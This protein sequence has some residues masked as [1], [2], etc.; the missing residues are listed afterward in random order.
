M[1]LKPIRRH[2]GFM[3]T[4]IRSKSSPA[5]LTSNIP[6]P[7]EQDGDL[8]TVPSCDD[9]IDLRQLKD[10]N[11]LAKTVL[12]VAR[13][14]LPEWDSVEEV[15][16]KR[17]SG[18]M[19]NAVYFMS[20]PDQPRVLLRVYGVGADQ[21]VDR[22]HE[23][24]WLARLSRM[25]TNLSPALLATF[26]NGRFEEYLESTTLTYNDMRTPDISCQIALSLRQLHDITE[27]YPPPENCRIECWRNISTWYAYVREM[28]NQ[29]EWKQKLAPLGLETLPK[30]IEELKAMT[31]KSKSPIVFAH[32]D[33]QYG[34]VLRMEKTGE[35]VVVDFE[36]AGYNPRGYDIANH[37]CEW[38]YDYHGDNSASMHMEWFP[39]NEEQLRF[40]NAY[41]EGGD[42]MG[43]TAEEL[44]K[45][46]LD[47]VIVT[48]MLWFLWGLVQVSQS[49]IDFDYFLYSTQRL[50]AFRKALRQSVDN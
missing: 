26:G 27:D 24:E 39:S 5:L 2:R 48:H 41:I 11:E 10:K 15:Q 35:L 46:V 49:E 1:S 19:T 40:L 16:L 30:E 29:E 43:L 13:K 7:E 31:E 47:W 20:A 50:N 12:E 8:E 38:M 32:N 36:Y 17:V 33:T 34:N 37:F 6:E 14:V 9:I 25:T 44:Q 21:L 23:L 22:Q 4:A 28:L 18:A 3:A 42:P 45:E